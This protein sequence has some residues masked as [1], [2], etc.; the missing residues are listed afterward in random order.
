[1]AMIAPFFCDLTEVTC[2]AK[3]FVLTFCSLAQ[4]ILVRFKW[5]KKW[6]CCF[7]YGKSKNGNHKCTNCICNQEKRLFSKI[8]FWKMA[9]FDGWHQKC[10]FSCTHVRIIVVTF[11]S[12]FKIEISSLQCRDGCL[13]F[14]LKIVCFNEF[15]TFSVKCA[16]FFKIWAQNVLLLR[17]S[18]GAD[19]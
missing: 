9:Y 4:Q 14:I 7:G 2:S 6:K 13:K 11:P 5:D 16:I 19:H 3:K 17:S 18:C 15:H 12:R 10:E 8:L 1:M